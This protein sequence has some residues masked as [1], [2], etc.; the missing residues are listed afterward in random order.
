MSVEHHII[1][2]EAAQALAG[3]ADEHG[4]DLI[5][6]GH[7]HSRRTG[8]LLM[9]GVTERLLTDSTIPLLVVSGERD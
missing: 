6:C 1:D 9:R 8:R 3:Y 5:V 2:G 4:F 7:H